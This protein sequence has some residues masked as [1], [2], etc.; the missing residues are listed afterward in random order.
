MATE[1]SSARTAS[2]TLASGRLIRSAAT[3]LYT[4]PMVQNT[5]R[6]EL[7]TVSPKKNAVDIAHA[8]HRG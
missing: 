1:I 7:K 8:T 5:V 3:D 4:G 6:V 2:S